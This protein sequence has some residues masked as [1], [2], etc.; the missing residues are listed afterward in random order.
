MVNLVI[1]RTHLNG[2]AV[3]H[4]VLYGKAWVIAV[5][6]TSNVRQ[7]DVLVTVI[8]GIDTHIYA[9]H[10]QCIALNFCHTNLSLLA[11]LQ[12]FLQI[13]TTRHLK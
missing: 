7:R 5:A 12:L 4:P 2:I 6:K 13:A 10:M 9:L 8:L 3:A 11:K 1:I